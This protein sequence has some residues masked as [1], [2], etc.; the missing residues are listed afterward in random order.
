MENI[1]IKESIKIG[2]FVKTA[3]K[4]ESAVRYV[5][6]IVSFIHEDKTK[7]DVRLT[8]IFT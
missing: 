2:D 5:D 1:T 8:V 6:A 4:N 7:C 3:I